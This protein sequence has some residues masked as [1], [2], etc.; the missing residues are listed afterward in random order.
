MEQYKLQYDDKNLCI[1]EESRF[2]ISADT[3]KNDASST[4]KQ[5]DEPKAN[6]QK[7]LN[8]DSAL[9]E[10]L[11]I[12]DNLKNIKLL[13]KDEIAEKV[14]KQMQ[15]SGIKP[16]QTVFNQQQK[17]QDAIIGRRAE[18]KLYEADYEK[19]DD[20][21]NKQPEWKPV[22]MGKDSGKPI[23]VT[24]RTPED[25]RALQ[26]QYSQCDQKFE[27]VRWID[28]IPASDKS[29]NDNNSN[30]VE[31]N[32]NA[33]N[34]SSSKS[35]AKKTSSKPKFYNIGGIEIKEDNG[36]IYQKQWIK[37]SDIESQNYRIINDKNNSIVNL[38]GK[39]IE[40][41]KWVLV[42]TSDADEDQ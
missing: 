38:N 36:N 12:K 13:S 4:A 3:I 39:S 6:D 41:K 9:L 11:G 28:P 24:F 1:D 40:M 16:K 18:I 30:D 26:Q 25:V 14:K 22:N 37:L 29:N 8:P 31:D 21:Y 35:I 7:M 5:S 42:E 19:V 10:S 20:Y 34:S 17:K 27:I 32:S 23:I 15:Q 2:L 33:L